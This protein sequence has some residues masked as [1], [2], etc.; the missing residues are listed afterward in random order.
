MTYTEAYDILGLAP[1]ATKREII[2]AFRQSALIN[3][4]DKNGSK[5][6]YEQ[7]MREILD[8]KRFLL[9][10]K[11]VSNPTNNKNTSAKQYEETI[12]EKWDRYYRENM[13]T[14]LRNDIKSM[15]NVFCGCSGPIATLALILTGMEIKEPLFAY[16][17]VTIPMMIFLSAFSYGFA[18]YNIKWWVN[19]KKNLKEY[20]KTKNTAVAKYAQTSMQKSHH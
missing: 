20:L 10:G 13:E 12:K 2:K 5:P 3:R 11:S 9:S 16:D 14:F 6:E 7:K 17:A 4:P 19:A 8:A 18:G 15:R 1:N